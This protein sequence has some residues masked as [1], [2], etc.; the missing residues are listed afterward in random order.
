MPKVVFLSSLMLMATSVV[1]F[2]EELSPAEHA[3]L[4][5]DCRTEGEASGMSG[6]DL[7]AYIEE[8]VDDFTETEISNTEKGEK[9]K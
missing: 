6:A 8:C 5:A 9:V 4:E 7:D 1:A 3:E 2:A